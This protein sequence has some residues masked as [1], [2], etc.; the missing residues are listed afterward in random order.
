MPP[1]H[2][3][4]NWRSPAWSPLVSGLNLRKVKEVL[5]EDLS[6]FLGSCGENSLKVKLVDIKVFFWTNSLWWH[7]EAQQTGHSVCVCVCV[8]GLVWVVATHGQHNYWTSKATNISAV[9]PG[10]SL[11]SESSYKVNGDLATAEEEGEE[12]WRGKWRWVIGPVSRA[13]D[14]MEESD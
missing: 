5:L 10:R 8:S 1:W 6:V 4:L 12:G 9:I 2:D 13:G 11:R 3:C 14:I 7:L